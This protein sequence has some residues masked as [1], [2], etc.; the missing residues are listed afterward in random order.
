MLHFPALTAKRTL[1]KERMCWY[2]LQILYDNGLI[3]LD[4]SKLKMNT[5][6]EELVKK[7]PKLISIGWWSDDYMS[8][9]GSGFMPITGLLIQLEKIQ[10][11]Y[12][13]P[14]GNVYKWVLVTAD[15]FNHLKQTKNLIFHYAK[16]YEN[17][18][19]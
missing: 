18:I 16:I 4:I 10:I 14:N 17:V 3:K 7:S 5:T 2:V 9:A 13:L 11:P 19:K 6:I 8:T 1:K 15:D 12:Y